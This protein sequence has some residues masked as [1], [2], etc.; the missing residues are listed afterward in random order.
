MRILDH[1]LRIFDGNFMSHDSLSQI[2]C[3]DAN[4]AKHNNKSKRVLS[5]VQKKRLGA[6]RN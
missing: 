5:V 1:Q 3:E 4:R 6:V 2:R